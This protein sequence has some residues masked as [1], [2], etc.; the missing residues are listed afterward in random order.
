MLSLFWYTG[1]PGGRGLPCSI[2]RFIATS[3]GRTKLTD[4]VLVSL[5]ENFGLPLTRLAAVGG[6][7]PSSGATDAGGYLPET[8]ET[9]T[10]D[11]A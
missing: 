4:E 10:V 11:M 1:L 5:K 3:Q 7:P 6:S 8:R 2:Q 9:Q